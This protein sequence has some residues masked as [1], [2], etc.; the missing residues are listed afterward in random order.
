MQ[1]ISKNTIQDWEI[2]TKN[3]C[4][5]IV[6]GILI[7]DFSC[8]NDTKDKTFPPRLLHLETPYTLKFAM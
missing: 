3:T 1:G 5:S 4:L 8:N 7:S 6:Y 2:F